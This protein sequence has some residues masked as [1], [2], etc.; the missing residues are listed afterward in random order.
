METEVGRFRGVFEDGYSWDKNTALNLFY[1]FLMPNILT[2]GGYTK[3]KIAKKGIISWATSKEDWK[4]RVPDFDINTFDTINEQ[5]LNILL[6]TSLGDLNNNRY[7]E[8]EDGK[9][10]EQSFDKPEVTR[11]NNETGELET[12]KLKYGKNL[13]NKPSLQIETDKQNAYWELREE[14]K[15]ARINADRRKEELKGAKGELKEK[16]EKDL[17]DA[18][19]VVEGLL[20]EL[21]TTRKR[22]YNDD[23]TLR[24]VMENDPKVEQFYSVVELSGEGLTDKQK[25]ALGVVREVTIT[26]E[27]RSK[28]EYEQLYDSDML[29]YEEFKEMVERKEREYI[30][31]LGIPAIIDN[32]FAQLSDESIDV[33]IRLVD[34]LS[35]NN[36]PTK[37]FLDIIKE[38]DYP[39]TI[40][41]TT[42]DGVSAITDSIKNKIANKNELT[43]L[44]QFIVKRWYSKNIQPFLN[45]QAEFTITETTLEE[46]DLKDRPVRI[47]KENLLNYVTDWEE[48][49]LISDDVFKIAGKSDA[50]QAKLKIQLDFKDKAVSMESAFAAEVGATSTDVISQVKERG[51]KKGDI[52]IDYVINLKSNNEFKEELPLLEA[53]DIFKNIGPI[54][55]R[56]GM[57]TKTSPDEAAKNAARKFLTR[58]KFNILVEFLNLI[59][60]LKEAEEKDL[61]QS[62]FDERT[63]ERLLDFDT[64]LFF[65]GDK[66]KYDYLTFIE[67]LT[68]SRTN[69]GKNIIEQMEKLSNLAGFLDIFIEENMDII[70]G[71]EEEIEDLSELSEDDRKERLE[72]IER[73]SR[74]N[75]A[76]EQERQ[77]AAEERELEIE[78]EEAGQTDEEG[79]GRL[80]GS[81]VEGAGEEMEMLE[82]IANNQKVVE[83]LLSIIDDKDNF[84]K[85]VVS[86]PLLK[87]SIKNARKAAEEKINTPSFRK[88]VKRFTQLLKQLLGR[89]ETLSDADTMD[90]LERDTDNLIE[91]IKNIEGDSVNEETRIAI[92]QYKVIITNYWNAILKQKDNKLIDK[93]KL[94]AI[95]PKLNL[96]KGIAEDMLRDKAFNDGRLGK[97]TLTSKKLVLSLDYMNR[98]AQLKGKISW[99]STATSTISYKIQGGKAPKYTG[100]SGET[101]SQRAMRGKFMTY[102]GK[103]QDI[104]Y[105]ANPI[106]ELRYEFF[107]EVKRNMQVLMGVIK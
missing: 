77:E 15:V 57:R 98:Q 9:E 65:S 34:L 25:I 82:N 46:P 78:Q 55:T 39:L 49:R 48:Q 68:N 96:E 23:I 95:I 76:S 31:M 90:D 10:V 89:D 107:Q 64:K 91:M 22:A 103:E 29:S 83:A 61:G 105:R 72:E 86:I 32:K 28:E 12:I 106:D 101:S 60:D 2:G 42:Y 18:I 30:K 11:I 79:E 81:M 59:K 38:L 1:N 44:F 35:N 7:Y 62:L 6:N 53:Q 37:R 66:F 73:E 54:L 26:N 4:R 100:A 36:L 63:E 102:Q 14:L 33:E 94:L 84:D 87:N 75:I 43:K 97:I 71:F 45:Q 13:T 27:A 51:T 70:Q 41:E 99:K 92:K 8:D 80:I 3:Q 93:R 74:R 85:S 24:Q 20:K 21:E 47:S 17:A 5:A 16:A 58:G 50:T 69:L 40:G 104:S 88:S 67:K 19:S 52:K 56:Y